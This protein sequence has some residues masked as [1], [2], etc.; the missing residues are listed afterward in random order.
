MIAAAYARY[1]TSNQTD[2]SIAYQL[3]EIQKYAVANDITLVAT[4][5][6]EA[7][8]GTN[9]DRPEFQRMVRDARAG[10]F[11]AVVIYDISRGSRD[12]SD[13][14]SFRKTMMM[15]GVQVIAATQRLG[16][17]TKSDDFLV[18]L[19]S[20]GLGQREVLETRTKSINGVAVR[21][22]EGVFLGGTPPLGYDIIDQQYVVNPTEAAMVKKIFQLYASGSSYNDI[23]A[24]LGKNAIGKHGRPIGKNSLYGILNN[25][26][27]IGVYTWNKRHTKFFRKWAG[28]ELNENVV[29]IEDRIPAI[30]DKHTWEEVQKRMNNNK[31]NASAKAKETYLLSGLIECECCGSMYV[32]HCS[33]NSRGYKTRYYVCGNKY[34][35]KSCQNPNVNADRLEAVVLDGVKDYLKQTDYRAISDEINRQIRAA[36]K[37][38]EAEKKEIQSIDWKLANGMRAILNGMDYPELRDEMDKLRV[39]K[40]ELANVIELTSRPAPEVTPEQ[41]E[42]VFDAAREALNSDAPKLAVQTC[43]QKIYAH[44]DGSFAI[45]IGVHTNGCGSAK[46]VICTTIPWL[47]K[48]IIIPAPK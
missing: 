10:K 48:R 47:F 27:Y 35:T 33:K 20:V 36:S 46:Q 6:D 29:R 9:T 15:L 1:S 32:G 39:R 22:N 11:K 8:S 12:V 21:A 3:A 37:S 2:N 42:S 40:S 44:T 5:A 18:E 41:I 28:G 16:D 7:F 30:I 14:F 34:R 45:D 19:I 31:R 23:L 13:W 38:C 25:E 26:R 17:I 4:Y 24:A 43:V